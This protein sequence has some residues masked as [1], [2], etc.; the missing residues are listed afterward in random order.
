MAALAPIGGATT[1]VGPALGPLRPLPSAAPFP[2]SGAGGGASFPAF[3]AS[4][5]SF[6]NAEA[7]YGTG[8]IKNGALAVV[9][10]PQSQ[11]A[12]APASG[13]AASGSAAPDPPPGAKPGDPPPGDPPA[14][15]PI[16][17]ATLPPQPQ[18]QT[19][20]LQVP[21]L[22]GP[23]P[24]PGDQQSSLPGPFADQNQAPDP[25]QQAQD[26]QQAAAQA[27]AQQQQ[28]AADAETAKLTS[29]LQDVTFHIAAANGEGNTAAAQQLAPIA[30]QINGQLQNQPFAGIGTTPPQPFAPPE[31]PTIFLNFPA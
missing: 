26:A 27:Q 28:N 13:S 16:P 29:S 11:A 15:P 20:G 6:G 19:P 17:I 2:G 1:A 24:G 30:T 21:S 25:L 7:G 23:F 9:S 12:P 5:G 18:P 3:P 14:Q 10:P 8:G 22:A 31:I 4:Y